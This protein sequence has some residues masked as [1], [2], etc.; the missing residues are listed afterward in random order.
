IS[1][2]S[3]VGSH[4]TLKV[5]DLLGNEVAILVDEFRE[6]GSYKAEFNAAQV[7]RPELS[8][9]LYLYKLTVG[10]FSASRKMLLVK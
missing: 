6:A 7:S 1:W 5:Y 2:Q 3:P 4:Q 9:G 10:S 8:S